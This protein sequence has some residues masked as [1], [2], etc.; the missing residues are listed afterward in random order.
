MNQTRAEIL[1]FLPEFVVGVPNVVLSDSIDDGSVAIAG[2][3]TRNGSASL[4]AVVDSFD[5]GEDLG[6]EDLVGALNGTADGAL[7]LLGRLDFKAI[8]VVSVVHCRRMAG[9]RD[10]RSGKSKIMKD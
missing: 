9:R 6:D 2:F 4:E 10:R 3:V 1:D 7:V 5:L 8:G